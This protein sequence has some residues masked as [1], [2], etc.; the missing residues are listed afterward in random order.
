ML[1]NIVI[2]GGG[3][4]GWMAAAMLSK[5]LPAPQ[6]NVT[7]VESDQIGTIGVGE[8]TI[9]HLTKFNKMLGIDEAEFMRQTHAT[10]KLGIE[11]VNW[12]DVGESYMHPF[13]SYGIP[14]NEVPFHHFWRREL[15]SNP[16]QD[17][18]EYS[19]NI[20]AARAGKFIRAV[21]DPL[22]LASQ[23]AHAY[24]LDA[25]LY[26]NFLKRF[27]I[28]HQ[29]H[30]VEG[31]I[32][33][34]TQHA[35][36]GDIASVILESGQEIMGDFFIDCSGFRALLIENTLNSGF[37]DWSHML[38]MDSAYAAPSELTGPPKPYTISTAQQAGWTWEIPLQHR[39][40]NG[41]VF[42]SRYMDNNAAETILR[43]K[44]EGKL[45]NEPRLI[46]FTTGHRKHF[47]K[48]NCVALGLASGFI[49]PL[50]STAIH[51]VQEGLTQLI[52]FLSNDGPR[53]SATKEYNRR[54]A[55]TYERIRDFIVLH[56]VITRRT[57]SSFWRDMQVLQIP[58]LLEHR[59]D[60]FART[61]VHSSYYLDIFSEPSWLA[62][63]QGQGITPEAYNPVAAAV[64]EAEFLMQMKKV[65]AAYVDVTN[66]MPTHQE[67]INHYCKASM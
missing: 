41:H 45:L 9:P 30:R 8:A 40:G 23:I 33:R 43:E 27:A 11:F 39:M 54:M 17:L 36:S 15:T 13:G 63:M 20:S 21:S 46:Q 29:A 28:K 6:F 5:F 51:L 44:I 35:G 47:W 24:H 32:S 65:K 49:E 25:N 38:P 1:K 26:A 53:P 60:L 55:N 2:V 4:A 16:N 56:Y 66:Q 67:F 57:D 18:G 62:V 37:E 22:H 10:F 52:G 59:M 64:P 12:G 50:E 3:T 61:G 7:L 19:L 58:D 31:K 34:I 48:K 42:S 14:F